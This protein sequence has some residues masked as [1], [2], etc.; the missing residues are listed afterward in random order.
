MAPRGVLVLMLPCLL[1]GCSGAPR[2]PTQP[3]PMV[4]TVSVESVSETIWSADYWVHY[5]RI[6][7]RETSGSPVTISRVDLQFIG[8]GVDATRTFTNVSGYTTLGNGAIELRELK[9]VDQPHQLDSATSVIATVIY[10]TRPGETG[11]ATGRG[12]VPTCTFR[13]NVGGPVLVPVGES[14]QVSGGWSACPSNYYPLDGSQIRW[15]SLDPA[16]ASV[17]ESG[18]VTGLTD[19]VA[20]IQG[21][22][23][24]VVR[25]HKFTIGSS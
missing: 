12:V 11:A 1:A 15:R 6:R 24:D 9:I 14:R 17:N 7:L 18:L 2:T 21:T 23:R 19:G 3:G 8:D 16:V 22:Y 10:T 25:S 5:V 4:K 13:F 20:T